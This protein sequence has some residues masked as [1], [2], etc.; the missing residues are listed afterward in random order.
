[1]KQV[2]F[3]YRNHLQA[4]LNFVVKAEKK[5]GKN[6][7]KPVYAKF[8]QFYNYKNEVAKSTNKSEAKSRFSGL[9]R[10]L[11]KGE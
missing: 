7:T 2:D 4:Y 9:G 1:M 8:E 6:K 11:K 3:D 5:S 10:F